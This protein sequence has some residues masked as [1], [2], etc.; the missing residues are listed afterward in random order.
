MSTSW[1]EVLNTQL[2]T[3]PTWAEVLRSTWRR[4]III[5]M[6][7]EIVDDTVHEEDFQNVNDDN[8]RYS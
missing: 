6:H 5:H 2:G 1:A 7:E 8:E 3:S 4:K